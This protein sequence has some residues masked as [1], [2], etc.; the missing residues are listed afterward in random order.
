MEKEPL[1]EPIIYHG[2]GGCP[3]CGGIMGLVDSEMTF[4]ELNKDGIPTTCEETVITCKAKCM[5]CGFEQNMI[6]WEDGYI[7]DNKTLLKYKK[8]EVKQRIKDRYKRLNESN[9]DKNPFF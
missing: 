7:P 8:Y 6:R 2:Y 9:K 3:K 5:D 1:I 4:M